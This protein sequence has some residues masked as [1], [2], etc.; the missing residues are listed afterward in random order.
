MR[1]PVGPAAVGR[2][3]HIPVFVIEDDEPVHL[4]DGPFFAPNTSADGGEENA[5][6]ISAPAERKRGSL[7]C[8]LCARCCWRRG[9][10]VDD[11]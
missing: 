8:F 4:P 11:G 5:G 1:T 10:E 2:H 7:L 9:A 6:L 3:Q